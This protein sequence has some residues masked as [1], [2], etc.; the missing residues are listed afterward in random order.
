MKATMKFMAVLIVILGV[1]VLQD[2]MRSAHDDY[3][4]YGSDTFFF[5]IRWILIFPIAIFLN[6]LFKRVVLFA[7][8]KSL[9]AK[10]ILFIGM[11][12][13]FQL[14]LFS[15][16]VHVISAIFYNQ[17]FSFLQ[18]LQFAVSQDLYKYLLIYSVIALILIHKRKKV[19]SN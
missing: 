17:I 16:V 19:N 13:I 3:S 1:A 2:N 6:I 11:A 15:I 14:L 12:S 18:N 5:S 7:K 8:I 9:F 4:F 10:R